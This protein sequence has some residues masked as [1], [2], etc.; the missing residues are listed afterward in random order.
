MGTTPGQDVKL[1]EAKIEGFRNF[2]NKLWNISRFILMTIGDSPA[3][4][5]ASTPKSAADEWI[6]SRVNEVAASVT[7]KIEKYE[8]S[9]AGEELREF[10]WNDLADWYLEIAKVEGEKT[11]ILSHLLKTILTLW[12]PYTPF[13]TEH[14][15]KTAGFEGGLIVAAWPMASGTSGNASFETIRTLVTDVRRLRAEQGVEA[16]KQVEVTLA[17][18]DEIRKIVEENIAVV[19]HLTRS[20]EIV[21]APAAP[22]GWATTVSGATTIALNLAGSVDVEKEK[23]KAQKELEDTRKYVDGLNKQLAN[24]EFT[25]KAPPS[26]VDKMKANL[27][28]AEAKLKALE[29][30]IK[31]LG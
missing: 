3:S 23:A 30:K 15:W 14:I 4:S 27:A 26:V 29:G 5:A 31:T 16:A 28:E 1:S 25:S 22:L 7:Q 11:E 13:V 19:K 20:E 6:L 9:S 2:T 12:H 10:T 8:F 24:D 18:A 21:F 17:G